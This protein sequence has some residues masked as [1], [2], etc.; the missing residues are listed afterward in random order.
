MNIHT[1]GLDVHL[2]A[3]RLVDL[4]LLQL[5]TPAPLEAGGLG[6]LQPMVSAARGQF[7]EGFARWL[8]EDYQPANPD[9]PFFV[10]I[11]ELSVPLQHLP[12]LEGIA[13]A[14][15]R[16]VF[17]IAGI[18]FL[19]FE[20]YRALLNT[21]ES[22]P[23]RPDWL[24]N[25]HA[26]HLV[27]AAFVVVKDRQNN[28]LRFVQTKRNPSDAEALTHFPCQQALLF[29]SI[30]QGQ[31]A[32][33]NFC[34]QICA[35]FTNEAQ[36]R[37]LRKAC[38]VASN[39]RQLDFTFVLQR[40]ENQ[41]AVHFKRSIAAY[42]EPPNEMTDTSAG[43]LLFVN[44]ANATFGKSDVWGKSMLLFPF[45]RRWR[46]PRSATYWLNDDGPFNHQAVVVRE[47]GPTVYWL[48][49]KPQYLVN[50]IPG[51]G[52]PCPF[53]DNR[54]LALLVQGQAFPAVV[55]FQVI[56]P[57]IHCWFQNGCAPSPYSSES[58]G[59]RGGQTPCGPHFGL[60][61]ATLSKG[62]RHFKATL[63]ISVVSRAARR[64]STDVKP[65]CAARAAAQT[66]NR[67]RCSARS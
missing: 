63:R 22:M 23:S 24:A 35:D 56:Q 17:I 58:F 43:C 64:F 42:F 51:A 8:R 28:I 45:A 44:N 16:P 18:E 29:Q 40:N 15:N 10:L 1:V 66:A 50:P 6:P 47:P 34:V 52:Q 25:G 38:E 60:Y 26:G 65:G 33:L 14:A 48:R 20:Q 46:V 36:V 53:I 32:R 59:K 57:V 11:P 49:Y 31:G 21:M 30:N 67:C 12:I 2:P 54:A 61:T 5:H 62:E 55:D 3:D 7:L 39:G 13:T 4:F 27:N 19:H 9:R 37:E 41:T